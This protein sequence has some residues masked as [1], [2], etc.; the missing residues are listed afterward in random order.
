[1]IGVFPTLIYNEVE[2]KEKS[3]DRRIIPHRVKKGE[4]QIERKKLER[5]TERKRQTEKEK[6][7]QRK[8]KT[9]GK[10]ISF[11]NVTNIKYNITLKIPDITT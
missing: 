3:I 8:K 7:R 6:D 10:K 1:M 5:R 2:V 9:P 11:T 4:R